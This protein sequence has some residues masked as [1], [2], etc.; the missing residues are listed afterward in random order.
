MILIMLRLQRFHR[1]FVI[2]THSVTSETHPTKSGNIPPS[3]TPIHVP[4]WTGTCRHHALTTP[5]TF[6]I[7]I[8]NTLT[9]MEDTTS[10]MI[11]LVR[12]PITL[13]EVTLAHR[14]AAAAG[15]ATTIQ[16][17]TTRHLITTIATIHHT[18]AIIITITIT[19]ITHLRDSLMAITTLIREAATTTINHR[20]GVTCPLIPDQVTTNTTRRITILPRDLPNTKAS[21]RSLRRRITQGSAHSTG[22]M[23]NGE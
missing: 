11:T 17:V 14:A 3:P 7:I 15:V 21:L 2:L 6:G 8:P 23:M 16:V 19:T 13:T 18:R 1:R 20:E 9:L 10:T 12:D 5:V 4:I 22:K